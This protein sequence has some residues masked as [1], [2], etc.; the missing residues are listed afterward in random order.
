MP[1]TIR[2]TPMLFMRPLPY[3]GLRISTR[4]KRNDQ[5]TKLAALGQYCAVVAVP[6]AK[7]HCGYP[8][9]S[10]ARAGVLRGFSVSI[11]PTVCSGRAFGIAPATTSPA[12]T[13]IR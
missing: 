5:L 4:A 13:R 6:G 12:V 10:V 7:N 9:V 8:A 2:T 11:S 3:D 1:N